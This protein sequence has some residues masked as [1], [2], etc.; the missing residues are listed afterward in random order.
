MVDRA[1]LQTAGW[2]LAAFVA[3]FLALRL[4]HHDS[5]GAGGGSVA[6]SAPPAAREHAP[7][8]AAAAVGGGRELTVDVAGEVRR[9]GV[10]RVPGGSRA[11]AA[12]QQAGGATRRADLTAV[13]LAMKLQDG[14][15]VVVPRRGAAVASPPAGSAGAG[16][17]GGAGGSAAGAAGAPQQPISL[18][19]ATVQQLD[20]LDGIGPTLAQRIVAYRDAHG[21]FRSID[22]L[23]QVSGIGDKRFQALRK[24]LQP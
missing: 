12:V 20:G 16:S 10:Y 8:P 15:Q 7:A 13:N 5:G 17:S 11:D 23:R 19:T 18:S 24:S 3:V 9:P 6:L 2:A 4:L 1:K 14:Q 22:E 21:G